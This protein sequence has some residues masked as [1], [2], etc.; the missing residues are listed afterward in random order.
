MEKNKII[1]CIICVI[2]VASIFGIIIKLKNKSKYS[3]DINAP[4]EKIEEIK[5]DTG[6]TADSDLYAV[7]KEYDGR[8]VLVIKPEIQFKT[9]LAG[10][11]KNDE[12]SMQDVENVNLNL[13]K[14]KGIWISEN[15]RN[16]FLEILGECN[17]KNF[18][19]DDDGY[20]KQL[21]KTENEYSLKLEELIQI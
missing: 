21:E 14:K 2:L 7:A 10:I 5:K 15:S 19:I 16:K 3:P 11:L 1:I 12:P 4:I 20:L 8:Q 17:I 18:T 9:V 6:A 13:F